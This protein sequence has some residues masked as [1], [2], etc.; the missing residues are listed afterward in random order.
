[1]STP[2]TRSEILDEVEDIAI[3]VMKYDQDLTIEAARSMVYEEVP[4]LYDEYKAS[5]P[6]SPAQPISKSNRETTLG[7]EIHAAI[8]KRAS[9]LAWTEW[10]HKTVEDLEWEVWQTDEGRLLYDLYRSDDGRLP[11]SQ[12][13]HTIAKAARSNEAWRVFR[14]WRAG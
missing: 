6:E 11:M 8:R 9:H 2:R 4:E 14:K 5:I 10:P 3:E 13:E 12:V 7:E 1:M